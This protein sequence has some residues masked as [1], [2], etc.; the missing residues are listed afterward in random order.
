LANA[1]NEITPLQVNSNGALYVE[2]VTVASHNVTNTG[3]FAV[4]IDSALPS[5]TN[6]IGKLSANSGVDIGDVDVTSVIPGTASANL[7]KAE[8]TAHSSG[9]V[10]VMSL[11]VRNDT[12]DAL[13]GTDGDYTPL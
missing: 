7:G 13:A 10:G 8:D 12:L 2:A 11:A 1:D 4:Q 5:G 6:S 3:T 9:D